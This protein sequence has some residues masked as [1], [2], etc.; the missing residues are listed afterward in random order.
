MNRREFLK[1]LSVVPVAVFAPKIVL[2][3]IEQKAIQK[4][5]IKKDTIPDGMWFITPEGDRFA[6]DE[7]TIAQKVEPIYSWASEAPV[8]YDRGIV[9]VDVF[10]F[11][12]YSECH[13]MQEEING[14][15]RSNYTHAVRDTFY[16]IRDGDDVIIFEFDGYKIVHKGLT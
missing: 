16:Y 8:M 12:Y 10:I 13:S 2:E 4:P 3:P 11:G 9:V 5:V 6:V 7:A 14:V 15:V 1:V